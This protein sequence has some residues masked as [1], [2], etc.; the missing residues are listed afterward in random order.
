MD[1]PSDLGHL[2][3]SHRLAGFFRAVDGKSLWIHTGSSNRLL[4]VRL[5]RQG[6][7]G[8][9]GRHAMHSRQRSM[10]KAKSQLQGFSG[11]CTVYRFV[12]RTRTSIA[13]WAGLAQQQH[14]G[15]PDPNTMLPTSA[16]LWKVVNV[17]S[18]K[19]QP[20]LGTNREA[21]HVT[22][23]RIKRLA[24]LCR[25]LGRA[26]TSQVNTRQAEVPLAIECEERLGPKG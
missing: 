14:L 19:Q 17:T 3:L 2:D 26:A 5:K 20:A 23:A 8:R 18:L 21:E 11:T 15:G 9:H 10:Q 7:H 12:P 24:N 6:R 1:M 22:A 25:R 4:H 13:V 16:S